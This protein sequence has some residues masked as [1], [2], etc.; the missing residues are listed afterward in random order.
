MKCPE[1]GFGSE[2]DSMQIHLSGC[3]KASQ[4]FNDLAEI[5]LTMDQKW[6]PSPD[7]LATMAAQIYWNLE[8]AYKGY[9]ISES[10]KIAKQICEEIQKNEI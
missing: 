7:L 2:Y 4:M 5:K 8:Q 3:Q 10:V 1:C 6:T 9:G